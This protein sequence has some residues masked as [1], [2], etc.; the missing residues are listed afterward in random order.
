MKNHCVNIHWLE[1]VGKAAWIEIDFKK[2]KKK[3]SYDEN[4]ETTSGCICVKSYYVF[5]SRL[6]MTF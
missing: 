2:E 6:N 5:R 4:F 3:N 1:R